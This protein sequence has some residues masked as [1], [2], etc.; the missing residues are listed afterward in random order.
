[1]RSCQW[2][3]RQSNADDTTARAS[4]CDV[5]ARSIRVQVRRSVESGDTCE[6]VSASAAC[7]VPATASPALCVIKIF[8]TLQLRIDADHF[9]KCEGA[10]SLGLAACARLCG[11]SGC[12]MER[13]GSEAGGASR[14]KRGSFTACAC[15]SCTAAHAQAAACD[16]SESCTVTLVTSW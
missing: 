1:M 6:R 8:A 16:P 11:Y 13:G 3:C 9:L 12:S 7:K 4:Y 2:S 14:D 15:C 5:T 10:V